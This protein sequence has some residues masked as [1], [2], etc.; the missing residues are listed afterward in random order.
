MILNAHSYYS[1]RYGVISNE[2]LIKAAVEN[3]YEAIAITDINNTSGVL[4]FVKLCLE[5]NI[6]PIVGMEFRKKDEL[7]FISLARNNEGYREINELMTDHNLYNKTLPTQ[8]EFNNCYVI[9]PYGKMNA[10]ELKENEFIG[11]RS[12]QIIKLITDKSKDKKKYVIL[13]TITYLD[14][15]GYEAHKNCER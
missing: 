9:Y 1:L 4:E 13:H 14:F 6:K 15:K 8:P 11:I 12:S 5:S 2:K 7:L 10:S 3:N